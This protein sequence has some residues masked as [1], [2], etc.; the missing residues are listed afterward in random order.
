MVEQ[1]EAVEAAQERAVVGDRDDR[2]LEAVERGLER[3]GGVDVEVVGRLVEQQQVVA[4]ELE[5]ED[6]QPRLLAAG[7]RVVGA[8][9]RVLQAVAGERAH[10]RLASPCA[11]SM[12]TSSSVRPAKSA[13]A[14][15]WVNSPGETRLPMHDLAGVRD[16]LAG[17]QADQVRLARAVGADQADALA[18]VDLLVER[19]HEP[20]DR[21]RRSS[22]THAAGGVAAAQAHLDLLV[23]DR[24]GRRAV[25]DEALP[26]RLHRV[27][28]LGPVR[29]VLGALLEDLHELAQAPLL[30]LPALEPVAEQLLA[31]L[32]RL[33]V[34][35]VGAAVDPGAVALERDDRVAGG[36][37]AARGRG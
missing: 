3:L 32:A 12:T 2:A 13:R 9:G 18:E 33:R 11:R 23:G 28:A 14:L 16:G 34:G 22:A 31:M 1:Q 30:V 5:A 29:R 15:S 17:Q 7:E 35:R 36:G 24:R 27:G 37:R 26:A 20:V 19:A 10:R 8:V 4:L 21:R 25:V 6:L